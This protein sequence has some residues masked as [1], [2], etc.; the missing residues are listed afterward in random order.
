MNAVERRKKIIEMLGSKEPLTGT[1]ISKSLMVSR[2]VIVQDIAILRA[3]GYGIVATPQGYII[4]DYSG[5]KYFRKIVA[6]IHNSEEIG[7]ELKIIISMGGRV[8]DVY[9]EHPV[10]GEIKAMLMLSSIF[11][12]EEFVRKLKESVGEPL[13]VLT[14]GIH[15]HTIEADD[16]V[17]LK[18]IED[19]LCKKGYLLNTDI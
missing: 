12:A 18:L 6:C 1:H 19:R 9:V 14:K 17:K 3:E 8:I 7:D 4:P 13:L 5:K 2:Q 10:Y 15:I 11:D 16:E